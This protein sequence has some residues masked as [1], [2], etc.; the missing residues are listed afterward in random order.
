MGEGVAA[1]LGRGAIPA[2]REALMGGG[3]PEMCA[4]AANHGETREASL[5]GGGGGE[6]GGR[7]CKGRG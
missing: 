4:G 6:G 7:G 2:V 1:A 3:V 5:M